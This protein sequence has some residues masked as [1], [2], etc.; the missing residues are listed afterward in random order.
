[1]ANHMKSVFYGVRDLSAFCGTVQT[2]INQIT[3][4]DGV[5]VGDN[6]ISFNRNL[7]FLD[8]AK[9]MGQSMSTPRPRWNSP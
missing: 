2:L 6:L 5:F 9:M 4:Q 1:M 8:D 7:S 3:V